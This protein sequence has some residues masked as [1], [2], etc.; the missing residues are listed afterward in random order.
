MNMKLTLATIAGAIVSF[1]LG[2]IVY[3][4]LLMGFFTANSIHYEGLM[5]EMPNIWIMI[6]ADL[7]MGFLLAFIFQRWAKFDT[8]MKGLY[9]GLIFGFFLALAMDLFSL[10]MMNLYTPVYVI[11]DIIVG[12][13][14]NGIVGGVIGW[15]LGMGKKEAAPAPPVQSE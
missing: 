2:W 6:I 3:G 14:M 7:S 9:G 8:F 13:I 1:F 15:I 12:T 10:S 5:L 4:L 11:V